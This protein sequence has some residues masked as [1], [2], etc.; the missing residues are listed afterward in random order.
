MNDEAFSP[1]R[2]F[3]NHL[4]VDVDCVNLTPYP[5][6]PYARMYHMYHTF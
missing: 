3:C 6:Q 4:V 2:S 1:H 5:N